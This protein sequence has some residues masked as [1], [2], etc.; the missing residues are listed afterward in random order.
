MLFSECYN[1]VGN[2]TTENVENFFKKMLSSISFF[3]Y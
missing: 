1:T 3:H 2:T